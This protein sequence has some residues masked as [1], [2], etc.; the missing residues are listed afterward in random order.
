[1]TAASGSY[2]D[3]AAIIGG[4]V[5][6]LALGLLF[7]G[8]GAA[9]G[10]TAVSAERGEASSGILA[11]VISTVWIVLS[12]VAAYAT[13]GYIAGRMRRRVDA[14]TADEV[15]VRDGMNGLI[16][17]AVGTVLSAIVIGSAISGAVSTAGSIAAT[18]VQA[19][20]AAVGGAAAGIA[21][22]VMPDGD[23]AMDYATSTLLRPS[24]VVPGTS[25][26]AGDAADASVILSKVVATG[27]I[28]DADRAY[29]VQIAAARSGLA[30]AQVDARVDEAVAA[31][32]SAR[33]EAARLAQEAEDAA[34]AAAETARISAILTAFLITAS[35]LVAAAAAYVCA[36]RGG[37]HRDEG[38]V[39][40][41]FA[42]GR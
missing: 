20:G 39:F 17:W 14:A 22:A 42:Y 13:G 34:R 11:I 36:V 38:R 25:D 40:G 33:A 12:M 16:V 18:G 21:G 26:A 7:T 19:A 27:E 2:V 9:L 24:T 41:G 10:L 31:A 37:R 23:A 35:A 5:I 15:Q 32:Q 28:S 30:P 29:L 4:A 8:F 6:A 3:W 1:M